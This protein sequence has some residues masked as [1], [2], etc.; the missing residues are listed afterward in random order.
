MFNF[1]V[2]PISKSLI[3]DT[4]HSVSNFYLKFKI[5]IENFENI[6]FTLRHT[7]MCFNL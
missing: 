2:M 1:K 3:F 7:E 6:T 4:A 5:R